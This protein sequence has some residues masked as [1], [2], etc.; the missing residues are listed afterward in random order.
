M[1]PIKRDNLFGNC[2]KC[3]TVSNK[4]T[5]IVDHPDDPEPAIIVS[6]DLCKALINVSPEGANYSD[7][8][9]RIQPRTTK[10]R[11]GPSSPTEVERA[12]SGLKYHYSP[13]ELASRIPPSPAEMLALSEKLLNEEHRKGT[14]KCIVCGKVPPGNFM[15]HFALTAGQHN[16][17]F[18]CD[19][20]LCLNKVKGELSRPERGNVGFGLQ[21]GRTIFDQRK[22]P[23]HRGREGSWS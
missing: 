15:C 1:E 22:K 13:K 4:V 3:G 17:L 23:N 11:T 6:C 8:L 7:L 5:T 10:E 18:T 12:A 14:L 21:S 2:P 16:Y 19:S 9:K 20:A